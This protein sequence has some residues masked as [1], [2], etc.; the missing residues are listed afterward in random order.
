MALVERLCQIPSDD[1]GGEP[2]A[3]HIALNPFCEAMFS[4]LGGYHTVTEVKAFYAMT[5]EDEAEFDTLVGRVTAHADDYHR[6]RAVHRIRS[7]LTFWEQGDV[8][9]YMSAAEIRAQLNAI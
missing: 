8:P 7:I 5:V 4:L 1:P 2:N 9:S 3:R 6:D